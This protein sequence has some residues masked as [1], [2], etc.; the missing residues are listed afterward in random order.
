[1]NIFDLYTDYLQIT[2]GLATVTGLFSI[3]DKAVSHAMIR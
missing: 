1:M 3:L 2:P